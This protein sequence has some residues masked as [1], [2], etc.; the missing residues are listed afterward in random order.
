MHIGYARTSTLDQIAGLDAQLKALKAAG[1]EKIF[2]E[3]LS[4]VD[5]HRLQLAALIDFAR[6]GD[7]VVCSKL[8]RLARSV[9]G[10]VEIAARLKSKGVSILILDP[11][12]SNKTPA[13]ELT[14]NLLSSIAQ[15]ERQ[16]MLERQREGIAKAKGEGKFTGRQ[17]TA[18]ARTDDVLKL[19]KQGMKPAEIA[20]KLS[21]EKDRKGKAQKISARSVYRILQDHKAAAAVKQG[22][23]GR[24]LCADSGQR[25]LRARW[26]GSPVL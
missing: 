14:F 2:R 23:A 16:V 4:S 1:C 19:Y 11:H 15:F 24:R 5:A 8:D 17:K 26:S 7:I 6:E 10:M 13:E 20:H 21:L 9:A 25:G 12:L 18:V 3:Q 22:R